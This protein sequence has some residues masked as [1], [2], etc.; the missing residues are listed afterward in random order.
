VS[1]TY[2][3]FVFEKDDKSMRLIEEESRILYYLEA[4]DIEGGEYVFWDANGAGVSVAVTPTTI[5]K[6]GKLKSVTV[7]QPTF[8]LGDALKLYAQSIGFPEIITEGQPIE[9]WNRIQEGLGNRPR[10][11][12]FL[13]KLLS[14]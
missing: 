7:S 14:G 4:I 12:S 6:T 8:P 3:L 5:L 9:V 1:V 13:S 2:P 10:R 11:R